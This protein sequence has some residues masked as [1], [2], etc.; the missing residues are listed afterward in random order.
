ME[1]LGAI[2]RDRGMSH[3]ARETGLAHESLYRSLNADGNPEFATIMKVLTS[4]GLRLEAKTLDS[5]STNPIK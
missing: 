4:I 3:I 1:T 5:A 2:A